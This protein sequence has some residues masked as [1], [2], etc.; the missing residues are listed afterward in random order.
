MRG[1]R[2]G[3]F[4]CSQYFLSF[5]ASDIRN[6]LLLIF[7]QGANLQSDWLQQQAELFVLPANPRRFGMHF[8]AKPEPC[9][10]VDKKRSFLLD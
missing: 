5:L 8:F 9:F 4:D 2:K 3:R 1:G 6:L 10:L 7:S